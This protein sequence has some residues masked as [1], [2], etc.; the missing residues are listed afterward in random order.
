MPETKHG[1]SS[2]AF[3]P[4]TWE[5]EGGLSPVQGQPEL[6]IEHWK[7]IYFKEKMPGYL[8]LETT[9]TKEVLHKSIQR[10]EHTPHY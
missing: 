10:T 6:H 5:A 1:G 4:S 2:H 9:L 8:S 3:H 7:F